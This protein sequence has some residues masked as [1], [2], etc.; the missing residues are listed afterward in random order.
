METKSKKPNLG[1]IVILYLLAALFLAYGI[2]RVYCSVEYVLT[3]D[4]SAAVSTANI[5]QYVVSDSVI[6]LGFAIVIFAAAYLMQSMRKLQFPAIPAAIANEEHGFMDEPESE[7]APE[8]ERNAGATP[9]SREES[10][11]S[12]GQTVGL[13]AKPQA[14]FETGQEEIPASAVTGTEETPSG[15]LPSETMQ[16]AEMPPHTPLSDAR[17]N[18]EPMP[19]HLSGEMTRLPDKTESSP[20]FTEN[21]PAMTESVETYDFK[22][23]NATGATPSHNP[24]GTES[25]DTGT[26]SPQVFAE[27]VTATQRE[28]QGFMEDTPARQLDEPMA[29]FNTGQPHKSAKERVASR[30]KRSKNARKA[31]AGTYTEQPRVP[32]STETTPLKDTKPSQGFDKA[33]V[34]SA[35]P[36]PEPVI[37]EPALDISSAES[38]ESAFGKLKSA[39]KKSSPSFEK[40]EP[41]EKTQNFTDAPSSAGFVDAKPARQ[42]DEPM[43]ATHAERPQQAPDANTPAHAQ[44]PQQVPSANTPAYA[45]RPHD[46]AEPEP[47]IE[48]EFEPEEPRTEIPAKPNA[49]TKFGVKY[50]TI[51]ITEP[52]PDEKPNPEPDFDSIAQNLSDTIRLQK[53]DHEILSNAIKD[54]FKEK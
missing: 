52:K 37:D 50:E 47:V 32:V 20:I 10:G 40:T 46:L 45:E 43:T 29:A 21:S 54:I 5:L 16:S 27:P 36:E 18:A 30:R 4:S 25:A 53:K 17:H 7:S 34:A 2:Y 48:L 35:K 33:S 28:S 9:N 11:L 24:L 13:E 6:Y 12:A 8:R 1:I 23:K 3:Y 15:S 41:A 42:F 44:Q 38:V 51:T 49:D 14:G 31:N 22:E 19:S 26:K 39:F